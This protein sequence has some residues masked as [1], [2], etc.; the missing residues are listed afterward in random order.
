MSE[1]SEIPGT[2]RPRIDD[3]EKAMKTYL[4]WRNQRQKLTPKEKE[5]K[6]ALMQRMRE[7]ADDLEKDEDGNSVYLFDDGETRQLAK[8]SI[9][10][11]VSVRAAPDDD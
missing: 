1:Q 9:D 3:I 2:E 4:K 8:F 10:E 11:N 7:H 5:A 6:E